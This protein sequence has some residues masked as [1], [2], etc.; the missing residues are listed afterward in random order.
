MSASPGLKRILVVEDEGDLRGLVTRILEDSGYAVQAAEDGWSAIE[1]LQANRPDLILLDL[2]LPVLDGWTVLEFARRSVPS[3]AVALMTVCSDADSIVRGL[4]AGIAGCV[5]KPFR[6]RDLVTTC[7][8]ILWRRAGYADEHQDRRRERRR[9]L[10][11]DVTALAGAGFAVAPAKL[12]DLSMGGAQVDLDASLEP[13]E[14]MRVS[15][16][17]FD[18]E[19]GG[20]WTA[21]CAGGA[22]WEAKPSRHTPRPPPA[23]PTAWP[24]WTWPRSTSASSGACYRILIKRSGCRASRSS[25]SRGGVRGGRKER[26][27]APPLN[28]RSPLW[29]GSW[30]LLVGVV[31]RAHQRAGLDVRVAEREGV[32][33]DLVEL[34]RA[35]VPQHG[36]MVR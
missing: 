36:Q 32:P 14:R 25:P 30:H 2:R 9:P 35:V 21:R 24:S 15:F 23:I 10:A 6:I 18:G 31:G 19:P 34:L 17:F 28:L 16:D 20:S 4:R 27:R 12:V 22:S 26:R 33:L 7:D 8:R 3:P 29:L 1:A 13:G 11:L 5:F